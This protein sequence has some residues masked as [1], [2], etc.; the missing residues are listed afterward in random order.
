MTLSSSYGNVTSSFIVTSSVGSFIV[1]DDSENDNIYG[2]SYFEVESVSYN[3]GSSSTIITLDDKTVTTTTAKI[4]DPNINTGTV[5]TN[6][7]GKISGSCAHAE[8]GETK[9]VGSRSHT[10]GI[11]SVAIGYGAHA[12]GSG[13]AASGIGSHAEGHKTR[14]SGNYSH[15]EGFAT[16]AS[17][18]YSHAAGYNTRAVG[19]ASYAGGLGTIANGDYRTVAGKY[20]LTTNTSSLFT[21]G[22]GAGAGSRKDGFTVD[23]D[24]NGSGSVMIPTNVAS[25]SV[26]KT[27][28][29]YVDPTNNKLWIF[30]GNG[31]VG[32]WVTASLG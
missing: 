10:E 27:G 23:V 32:G 7:D 25:P 11:Y 5:P 20:N 12:E 30:T 16:I 24:T 1:L 4:G 15:A 9:A 19:T 21:V 28:S 17:G 26:A 6:S 14:T 13:S 2:I 31:G 3:S 18:I 22:I 29:M 8:G